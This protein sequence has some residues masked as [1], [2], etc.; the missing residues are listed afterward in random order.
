MTTPD[1]TTAP[2]RASGPRLSVVIP[3]LSLDEYLEDC[4]SSLS[5]NDCFPD[6]EVIVVVDGPQPTGVPAGL[7]ELENVTVIATGARSGSGAATNRGRVEASGQF[8]ARM[9]ADD[10]SLPG[11]LDAQLAFL[12]EHPQVQVCGGGGPLVDDDGRE[13]GHYPAHPQGD[14][15]HTLLDRNPVVHSSMVMSAALFDE[16]G[17][18]DP[19]CIRMQDYELLLR[20]ALRSPIHHFGDL[21]LVAYRVHGAQTSTRAHGFLRLMRTIHTR[22]TALARK[23]GR[24]RAA[25]AMSDAVY[26]AAQAARYAG[27][28]KPRYLMGARGPR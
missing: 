21:P 9:D 26:S 5:E 12:A 8:I 24:P 3:C 28:R 2:P 6:T 23:L 22:R 7:A 16:L 13:I 18:Y 4:V 11:R 1:P 10:L 20:A 17:G 15:R 25:Q 27:L 19:S 14:A